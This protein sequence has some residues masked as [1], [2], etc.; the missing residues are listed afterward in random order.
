M[1]SPLESAIT[2]EDVFAMVVG[3]RVP[4]APELAGYLSL[5]IAEKADAAGSGGGDIDPRSVYIADEGTVALVRPQGA[6]DEGDAEQSIRAILGQLLEAS[7]SSTPALAT[8]SRH[9]RSGSLRSLM[10]SIEAALIPVNRAAGRRALA[11]LAREVKRVTHGVGRNAPSGRSPS[12]ESTARASRSSADDIP[13]V[14]HERPEP[15]EPRSAGRPPSAAPAAP[16]PPPPPPPPQAPP[17][18]GETLIG[19]AVPGVAAPPPAVSPTPQAR[20]AAPPTLDS[21]SGVENL[22]EQFSRST[23]QSAQAVSRDLKGLV[24]IGETAVPPDVQPRQAAADAAPDVDNLLAFAEAAGGTDLPTDRGLLVPT[25]L[26]VR[27]SDGDASR[28]RLLMPTPDPVRAPD[29]GLDPGLL[30]PTPEPVR[31]PEGAIDPA[32][33]VPTPEPVRSPGREADAARLTAATPEPVRQPEDGTSASDSVPPVGPDPR[34]LPTQPSVHLAEWSRPR[35][36][37]ADYWIVLALLAVLAAAAAAVWQLKPGLISGRTPEKIAAERAAAE[38]A[39]Q[40]AAAAQQAL[41][42]HAALDVTDVPTGAEVLLRIG[43]APID[44]PRLP[45]GARLEFVATAEGFAPKRTVIPAGAPWDKGPDGKPRFEAAVQLDKSNPKAKLG[46][47]WPPGEEGSEVGG[48]GP[49]G[50]VHIVSTPRGAEI[51]MLAGLGPEALI[52]QLPCDQA[53]DVLV[54]GPTTY[55]KRMHAAPSDFAARAGDA[56]SRI[57]RVKAR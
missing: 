32:L 20:S 3:K 10:E 12:G 38:L 37:R 55:R 30:M 48:K 7:G 8:V 57:A 18:R 14:R 13:A 34:K 31:R 28:A 49:P 5:E 23:T 17:L 2:L 6:A 51:W 56:Q 4:L 16:T 19:F 47:S 45:V 36:K 40:N 22:L 11:R 15:Q 50:T 52:E 1:A 46:D 33:L 9:E 21:S 53:V 54:A 27:R 26:P 25:P 41:S 39:K 29:P 42:C 24:D 43:Q 44:I 35:K